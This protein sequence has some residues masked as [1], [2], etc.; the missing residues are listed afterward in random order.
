MNV[1]EEPVS[2]VQRRG[3]GCD[4]GLEQFGARLHQRQLLAAQHER[5]ADGAVY[6]GHGLL[7]RRLQRAVADDLREKQRRRQVARAREVHRV[8]RETQVVLV[9]RAVGEALRGERMDDLLVNLYKS[10]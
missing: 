10:S 1:T 3:H 4:R 2:S 5:L 7:E 9:R 6:S 8:A